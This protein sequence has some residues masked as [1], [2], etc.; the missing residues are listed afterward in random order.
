[1]E[2]PELRIGGLRTR[3][4]IVQGGMGVGISLSGLAS[5][6]ANCGGV[7]VI[8]T[9]GIGMNHP[10]FRKHQ[11][12]ANRIALKEEIRTAREKTR[13]VIGVNIMVALTDFDDHVDIALTE[14]IDVIFMGAGLPL[15]F[16][17]RIP[18]ERLRETKTCFMPI[19]SSGRAAQLVFSHWEKRFG[20]VPDGAVVE[21]PLA[22]GHLGFRKEQLEDPACALE[23]LVPEVI[24]TLRHFEQRSGRHLPVIAAGGIYT[25]SDIARFFDLGA[26]GVQMGTRF[27]ATHECDANVRFKEAYIAARPEDLTII[28]S[29][30]GLPGRAIRNAF[31]DEVR[32]GERKPYRCAWTCLKTCPFKDAPYCI[33]DALLNAQRGQLDQGFPFAGANA[34]RVKEIVSVAA[35]M[36]ELETE[37]FAAVAARPAQNTTPQ[38]VR[39]SR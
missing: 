8:S 32:A 33:G 3:R 13:G 38:L 20:R 35:L 36:Q 31:L 37:Y 24:A 7:G 11:R 23:I 19:V 22:G 26:S 30:V 28:E 17:D 16:S 18:P 34:W 9:V 29:P 39:Q 25:G 1:M 14:G 15:R 10:D 27:V 4:P 2:M 6:V 5:A 21:G 12:E